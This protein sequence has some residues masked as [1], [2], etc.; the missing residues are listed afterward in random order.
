MMSFDGLKIEATEVD[1]AVLVDKDVYPVVIL[2][3]IDEDDALAM[4][5]VFG[6]EII[7]R[8]V[9]IGEWYVVSFERDAEEV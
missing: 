1:H 5:H 3:C 8:K 7:S 6:G 2:P 9:Y 4:Q